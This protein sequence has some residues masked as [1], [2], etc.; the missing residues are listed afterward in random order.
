MDAGIAVEPAPIIKPDMKPDVKPDAGAERAASRT[1]GKLKIKASVWFDVYVDGQKRFRHPRVAQPI[2]VGAHR[3][4]LRNEEFGCKPIRRTI[5]VK[6]A[7]T[8]T[9]LARCEPR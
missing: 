5:E 2:S 6:S 9:V 3:I 8:T 7:Q 1:P 4:E